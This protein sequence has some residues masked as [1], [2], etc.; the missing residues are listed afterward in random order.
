MLQMNS[1][2]LTREALRKY[3]ER[4]K[5]NAEHSVHLVQYTPR[6]YLVGTN[7]QIAGSVFK[8]QPGQSNL[9]GTHFEALR[10]IPNTN[11]SGDV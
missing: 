2:L 7:I 10:K 11:T 3:R 9:D 5:I 4:C 8:Y 6:Q 1:T